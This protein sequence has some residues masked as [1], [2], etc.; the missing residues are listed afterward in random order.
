MYREVLEHMGIDHRMKE[1]GQQYMSLLEHN[2]D[3][4]LVFDVHGYVTSTNAACSCISGYSFEELRKTT[5]VDLILPTD[6]M[7]VLRRVVRVLRG[8]AENY[9]ATLTRQDGRQV[10]ISVKNVPMIVE[11]EMC[12]YFAIVRDITERVESLRE[13]NAT[14]RQLESFLNHSTDAINVQDMEGNILFVNPAFEHMFGWAAEEVIGRQ[15]PTMPME[16]IYERDAIAET[17]RSGGCISGMDTVRMRRDGT[18]IHT[19]LSVSPIRNE[20]GEVTAIVGV[21]RDISERIKTE[22]LLRSSEKLAAL[23]QLAAGVAHEIRNPMT[24]LRGFVQL[25]QEQKAGRDDY[26]HIMLSE[27]QRV[28]QIVSEFLMLSKPHVTQ[29]AKRSVPTILRQVV[30]L[31]EAEAV[32]KDVQ[33]LL[34]CEDHLP[35]VVCDAGQLKQVFVNLLKNAI[36][37]MPDG[38]NLSIQCEFNET[39]AVAIRFED[40]GVGIPR[41]HLSRLCEPFFTTKP[42]GTGLGLMVSHK[43]MEEHGGHLFISS[44]IGKGT[45][46]EVRFPISAQEQRSDAKPEKERVDRH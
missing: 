17:V 41:E 29:M 24:A 43:I 5:I 37:A 33:I 46:V 40:E 12:G 35:E 9:E 30:S 18:R 26:F 42:E 45:M 14:K 13:L 10:E 8:T 27:L 39:H 38:G 6:R 34:H 21:S 4:I 44:D 1:F 16:L 15:I 20:R 23:G 3:A 25:L 7:R 31:L 11:G 19:S 36:E 2:P 28:E 32:L 22:E